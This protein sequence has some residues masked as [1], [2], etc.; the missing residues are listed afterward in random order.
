[1]SL[2]THTQLA[3]T[4]HVEERMSMKDHHPTAVSASDQVSRPP[5]SHLVLCTNSKGG[6]HQEPHFYTRY[7][8]AAIL[9]LL[10]ASQL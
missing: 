4:G 9:S 2:C 5:V 3:F 6:I 1:M 7:Q 10:T 8:E